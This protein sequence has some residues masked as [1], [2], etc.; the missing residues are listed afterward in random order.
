[1]KRVEGVDVEFPGD[2][3]GAVGAEDVEGQ[4]DGRCGV[5]ASAV[6]TAGHALPV[7]QPRVGKRAD[8]RR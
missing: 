1:M 5:V 7:D 2:V 3:G 8:R 6:R 4:L